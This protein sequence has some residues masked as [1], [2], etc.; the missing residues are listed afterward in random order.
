MD[1]TGL[2]PAWAVA[3]ENSALDAYVYGFV[4]TELSLPFEAYRQHYLSADLL[5]AQ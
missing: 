5:R 2:A 4:L 3:L 1:G